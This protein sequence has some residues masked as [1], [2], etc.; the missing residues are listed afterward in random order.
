MW[1][2]SGEDAGTEATTNVVFAGGSGAVVET[3][4]L[5]SYRASTVVEADGGAGV[6]CCDEVGSDTKIEFLVESG[7]KN[8]A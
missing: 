7:L 8:D 3:G 1:L 4:I 5:E 6:S 2:D